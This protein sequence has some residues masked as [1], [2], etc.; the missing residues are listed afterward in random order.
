MTTIGDRVVV[1]RRNGNHLSDIIGH[2]I[3]LDPLVI[4]PQKVGGL[5][6]NTPAI[7]I[8]AEDIQI[9]RRLSPRR[10]R[11]SE[12]RELE[13]LTAMAFPGTHHQWSSNGQWLMRAGHGITERS[14]S[15]APLGP[16]VLYDQL[17]IKELHAFY[18]QHGL[19]MQILIPDR[20]APRLSPQQWD[21]G[22]DILVMTTL[23]GE[24]DWPEVPEF[25]VH[26]RP[27]DYWLS[28]Y[29]FRGQALPEDDGLLEGTAY[30][31]DLAGK[32]IARL[33]I[34]D[35]YVGISGVN[36]GPEWRRQGLGRVLG[37]GILAW[38]A[39]KGASHAYLQVLESNSAGRKLYESLG[40][41]EH[42]RHRYAR[43]R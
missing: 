31:V 1:R 34:L 13:R 27:P 39:R 30:Y 6:S 25:R 35:G 41:I 38:A 20:I 32:A 42:H 18:H 19:P 29:E 12:I 10:V 8:P 21:I 37:Q 7:S 28:L 24:E 23:I 4:R 17:P 14:N 16:S 15:A 26:R 40:F 9:I 22:P 5:P 36:V 11:N 2:V 43:W 3:S 33:H